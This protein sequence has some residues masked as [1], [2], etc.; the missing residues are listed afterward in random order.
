RHLLRAFAGGDPRTFNSIKVRFADSV[1]PGETL[2]TEMWK[3]SATRI[4]FQ[5]K[6][7]E[8]ERVVISNAAIELYPEV[9][10]VAARP[11][12][13]PQA[14]AVPTSADIFAAIS[15]YVRESAEA[16][17]RVGVVYQ[18]SL[19]DPA[20]VWTVDLKGGAV[21]RGES[22]APECKLELSDAD[23]MAMCTGQADP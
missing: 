20:S 2:V 15:R 7:A 3:E 18:F 12:P 8:R 22:V 4:V 11:A 5:C 13:P 6:V 21:A 19:T 17:K 16:V 23:F 1:V 10:V 9:P 14:A